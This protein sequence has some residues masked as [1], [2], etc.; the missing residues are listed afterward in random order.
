MQFSKHKLDSL[1][2]QVLKVVEDVVS[3]DPTK[4]P[5]NLLREEM[6]TSRQH[7]MKLFQLMLNHRAS[8]SYDH[9][10]NGVP[11][12]PSMAY[13]TT[14]LYPTWQSGGVQSHINQTFLP[15]SSS[16]GPFPFDSGKYLPLQGTMETSLLEKAL[17]TLLPFC[18]CTYKK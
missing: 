14:G 10:F 17:E 9:C 8:G 5:M 13:G 16:G 6:E 7:Q 1:T 18:M 2:S 4:D 15:E 11:P 12:P 3:N